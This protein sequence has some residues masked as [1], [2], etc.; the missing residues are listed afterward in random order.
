MKHK[1]LVSSS[2]AGYVT[3]LQC[4]LLLACWDNVGS[5]DTIMHVAIVQAAL[6][7]QVTGDT[8]KPD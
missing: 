1:S 8:N 5:L 6:V 7:C 4:D 2:R 3:C